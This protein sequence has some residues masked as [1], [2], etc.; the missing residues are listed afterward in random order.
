MLANCAFGEV[1]NE[2]TPIIY[3]EGKAESGVELAKDET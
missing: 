1:R 2:D 3:C